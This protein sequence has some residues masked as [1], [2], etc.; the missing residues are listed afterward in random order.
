MTSVLWPT[1]LACS[2]IKLAH[3]YTLM[4]CV[5]LCLCVEYVPVHYPV[6]GHGG[7]PGEGT[8]PGEHRTQNALCRRHLQG[9]CFCTYMI[10]MYITPPSPLPPS[11]PISVCRRW[12]YEG[13][14]TQVQRIRVPS[15]TPLSH[16]QQGAT[17]SSHWCNME[18]FQ[19]SSHSS[20][21]NYIITCMIH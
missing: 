3:P 15:Q 6:R 13:A 20:T 5:Y 2:C 10:Y 21:V 9:V 8:A 19:E 4:Y 11:S 1:V 16:W 14:G 7:V 17:D 18:V 12:Q